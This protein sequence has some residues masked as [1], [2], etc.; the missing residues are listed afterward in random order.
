MSY[1]DFFLLPLLPQHENEYKQQIKIFA[2][3]MKEFG[4]L[5]YCETKADQVP[6]GEVTDFYRAVAAV[7]EETVVA[8][9]GIWPDKETRDRAWSEGMN[10]PRMKSL[11]G[12]K[13]L[14]DG[15]RMVYGGFAP[16]FESKSLREET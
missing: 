3:V 7:G 5:Y 15:K 6:H 16:L 9:F 4:L 13:R 14:F 2:E 8:G 11:D 12:H 1:F 10:D